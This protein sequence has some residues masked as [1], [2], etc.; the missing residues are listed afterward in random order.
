MSVTRKGI[1]ITAFRHNSPDNPVFATATVGSQSALLRLWEQGGV[2]GNVTVIMP[3]GSKYDK[4]TPVD[5]RGEIT[6]PP[7]RIV[8][9]K[10]TFLLKAYAPASFVLE[11]D[12]DN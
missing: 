11:M 9:G 7:V 8:K 10:L 4:A 3:K 5:L 1:Q 6:G 2:S 12:A